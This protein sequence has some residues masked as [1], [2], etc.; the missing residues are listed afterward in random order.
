MKLTYVIGLFLSV[1]LSTT[2]Y[3]HPGGPCGSPAER[4]TEELNLDDVQA[5]SIAMIFENAK[6]LCDEAGSRSE[7][8]E[9]MGEQQGLVDDQ[10]AA[11]LTDEQLEQFQEVQADRAERRSGPPRHR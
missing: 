5:N 6:S 8:R 7:H 3:A 1:L 9:C 10:I 4:L 11:L 2:A